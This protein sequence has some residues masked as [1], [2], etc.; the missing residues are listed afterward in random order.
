MKIEIDGKTLEAIE[1]DI[2]DFDGDAIVNAANNHFWLG[3]GVAGAIK[4]RGG[5]VIEEEAIRQGPK[6]VGQSIMTG[7]GT[8]NVK[9]VIHAAV[10]GQD[11][12]TDSGKVRAATKSSLQLA[13]LNE[14]NSLAFPA[15]GT[16]VGGFPMSEAAKIMVGESAAFLGKSKN[17]KSITFVLFGDD[18][19]ESFAAEIRGVKK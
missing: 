11:L 4:R 6:P 16:G 12:Q 13:E 9:Y 10:M 14:V 19:Y 5:I 15:L 17:L 18:A 3:G 8:L 7:A 1:G 2:T